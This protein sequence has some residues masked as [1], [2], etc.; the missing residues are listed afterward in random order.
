M[1]KLNNCKAACNSDT[2]Y[3]APEASCHWG[4]LCTCPPPRQCGDSG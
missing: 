3:I 1:E 4:T 2:A